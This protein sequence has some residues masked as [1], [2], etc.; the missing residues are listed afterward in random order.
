[1]THELQLLATAA[2]LQSHRR[3]CPHPFS[4]LGLLSCA[5]RGDAS[6]SIALANE[7]PKIRIQL[8]AAPARWPIELVSRCA[9]P[10]IFCFGDLLVS[11]EG[12]IQRI[13]PSGFLRAE[14]AATR[15]LAEDIGPSESPWI[16]ISFASHEKC[17][18]SPPKL[19]AV[20]RNETWAGAPTDQTR[21]KVCVRCLANEIAVQQPPLDQH[22]NK[23]AAR[24]AGAT[25]VMQASAR[26]FFRGSAGRVRH[27]GTGRSIPTGSL[28]EIPS[29]AVL[30]VDFEIL[31]DGDEYGSADGEGCLSL[32]R[33][34]IAH[35]AA[36]LIRGGACRRICE[37]SERAKAE[38]A[39]AKLESRR[40]D[41][42]VCDYVHHKRRALYRVPTNENQL[43]SLF[44]K[45]EACDALPFHIEVLEYTPKTGID[46]I[47]HFRIGEG[48]IKEMFAPIEF[49][50][51][52]GSFIEHGH[53]ISHTK[54]IVCWSADDA[55]GRQL[56]G[57]RSRPWLRYLVSGVYKVPVVV[58]SK[59]PNISVEN[60]NAADTNS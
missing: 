14:R 54:L 7:T 40:A 28:S 44:L 60:R 21:R 47:G 19:E 15:I 50:Y 26:S 49:E 6:V 5:K 37:L 46:A 36:N 42:T 45:L 25:V 51:Q 3:N 38:A 39:Q 13:D 55:H 53:P 31:F 52:F 35:W 4:V 34:A 48:G 41:L 30:D 10:S 18:L 11:A 9:V 27:M 2:T 57:S 32:A 58:V 12:R 23:A 43:V 59:L 16:E 17:W 56:K 8:H 29:G 1:V 22:A 20:L 33:N 24:I